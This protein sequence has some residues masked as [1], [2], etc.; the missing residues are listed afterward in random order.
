MENIANTQRTVNPIVFEEVVQKPNLF[1]LFNNW[2]DQQAEIFE[3]SRFG[4]MAFMLGFQTCLGAGA[5]ALTY[6]NESILALAFAATATMMNNT[7][8]LAQG[9]AK[10]CVGIFYGA[11]VVN[12]AVIITSL[13]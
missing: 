11:F 7:V 6:T 13:F 10:W 12:L 9:P 8:L 2:L 1:Q 5:A 3:T 4:I